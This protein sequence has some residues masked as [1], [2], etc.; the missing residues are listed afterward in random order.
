VDG[1]ARAAD[2]VARAGTDRDPVACVAAIAS[3]EPETVRFDT[4][5]IVT[6]SIEPLSVIREL[7]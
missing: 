6:V 1:E 7:A 4:A 5:A 3:F 2:R